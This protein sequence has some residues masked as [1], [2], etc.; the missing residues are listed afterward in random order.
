M[1]LAPMRAVSTA[2]ENNTCTVLRPASDTISSLKSQALRFT[3]F[4]CHDEDLFGTFFISEKSQPGTIGRKTGITGGAS[5]S[6]ETFSTPTST[7][8]LPEIIFCDKNDVI[9]MNSR[10]TDIP[11]QWHANSS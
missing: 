7:G 1:V 9:I 8:N 10:K 6:G 2:G 3:A 4:C 5:T 11:L